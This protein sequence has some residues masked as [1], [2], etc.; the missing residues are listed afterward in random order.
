MNYTIDE[1]LS[2]I[3]TVCLKLKSIK[4]I[5]NM[6]IFVEKITTMFLDEWNRPKEKKEEKKKYKK[7]KKSKK[8]KLDNNEKRDKKVEE[9]NSIKKT[10]NTIKLNWRNY[11][12]QVGQRCQWNNW[13]CRWT[14]W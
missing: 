4:N 3:E 2:S 8:L 14:K 10:E 6:S 1:I 9:N 11:R 7:K 12:Y 13:V 5:R